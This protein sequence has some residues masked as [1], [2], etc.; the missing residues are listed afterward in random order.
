[1]VS[2]SFHPYKAT[3]RV[4]DLRPYRA[5]ADGSEFA[6]YFHADDHGHDGGS[7]TVFLSLA[8]AYALYAQIGALLHPEPAAEAVDA[9]LS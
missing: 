3:V 2:I 5:V 7:G 1:M 9:A 4:A 6:V 8:Q